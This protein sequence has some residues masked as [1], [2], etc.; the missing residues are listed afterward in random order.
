NEAFALQSPFRRKELPD[1]LR[2]EHYG[3][4][5]GGPIIK[6][7]T[8]FFLN[9]E[10]QNY[11]IADPQ[12][13]TVPSNAWID[14]AR[15]ILQKHNVPVNPVMLATFQNPW[16]ARSASA[17]ATQLNFASGDDDTGHSNNG[18]IKIDQ[19]IGEKNTISAR[20]F[21]GTGEAAQFAD[22]VYREYYQVVPSRQH[23]F[24]VTWNSTLTPRLVN[25]M[26]AGV[27]YFNQTFD[28]AVHAANPPSWGLNTGVTNPSNFGAPTI[29]LNGFTSGGV[30]P[31]PRLG[32]IDVTGHLTDNLSY[33]FGS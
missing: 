26:L 24:A 6:N 5:I 3:F 27:N 20:A 10:K 4:S 28:D 33:N 11:V 32:R 14:V 18:I 7:R 22:S 23:N 13:G 1:K 25:Q 15:G 8:F 21:L 29:T 12:I 16:P 17:P 9:Y 19:Q 31:T 2:N 30:G